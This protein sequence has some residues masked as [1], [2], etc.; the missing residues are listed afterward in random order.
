MNTSNSATIVSK[1]SARPESPRNESAPASEYNVALGYLRAFIVVLVVAH[2]AVLAYHPFA[3]PPPASLVAQPRFWQ[4]FPVVDTH[5]STAFALFVGFNDTFFM[6]LMFLLSGL[7]VWNSLQRK[8]AGVFIWDRLRR[9]GLP[10]LISVAL[11]APIAYFPA[12]LQSAAHPSL[13]AFREQWRS[14]GTWP[15]GP[16]WFLWVLLAFDCVAAGMFALLPRWAEVITARLSA[17]LRSPL[18]FFG[19]LAAISAVA[20]LPMVLK[21]TS[22]YWTSVGPFTFQTSRIF[23][24]AV[25]FL[26][27]II[28]GVRPE[29]TSL[30]RGGVLARRWPIWVVTSL[31]A[32]ALV[33]CVVIL[34]LSNPAR[35]QTWELVG[36]FAFVISCA[37]SSFAFLSLFLRF[38]GARKKVMDSLCSN[39]YG[40]YLFHYIFVNWAQLAVLK[41]ELPA[42]AKGGLVFV[43]AL[44]LSWGTTI[45]LRRVRVL[46]AVI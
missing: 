14:L 3:P 43:C 29:N 17:I 7:F 40:I 1:R 21:F 28:V 25:Y 26:V 5:R 37:T 39:S 10:F 42:L 22:L 18:A 23:H 27:G 30:S 45:I 8:G 41:A 12:Y 2:H 33:V 16:A 20:Y 31:I 46:A 13:N 15:A 11:L 19:A 35:H 38:T 6:S 9:L 34:A 32:F 36:G 4:A 44:M 24:Y